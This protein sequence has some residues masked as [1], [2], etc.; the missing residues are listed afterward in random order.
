MVGEV[1][2]AHFLGTMR[3]R[4]YKI[5]FSKARG[6]QSVV[7]V[8]SKEVLGLSAST[9]IKATCPSRLKAGEEM[10]LLWLLF[11]WTQKRFVTM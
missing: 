8:L 7:W 10:G 5:R 3:Q 11:S 4:S 1:R 2:L 9:S 6:S